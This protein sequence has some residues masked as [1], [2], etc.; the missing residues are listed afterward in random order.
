METVLQFYGCHTS[1]M[2]ENYNDVVLKKYSFI[3]KRIIGIEKSP[4]Y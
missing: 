3:I 1:H 2:T 4:N